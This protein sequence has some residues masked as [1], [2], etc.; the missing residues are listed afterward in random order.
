MLEVPGR[1]NEFVHNKERAL[2]LYEGERAEHSGSDHERNR[3]ELLHSVIVDEDFAIIGSQVD[4]ITKRKIWDGG[5]VDFARLILRDRL[6][7]IEDERRMEFIMRD[8]QTFLTPAADR[9]ATAI[10]SFNRREQAFRVFLVIYT[11]AFPNRAKELI[12]YNQVIFQAS[13]TFQWENVYAYDRDFHLHLSRHPN[14]TW[15]VILQQSWT[16]RMKDRLVKHQSGNGNSYSGR[17]KICWQYNKGK[18][19]FGV[20]CKFE[21]KCSVP[22]CGKYGHGAHICRKAKNNNFGYSGDCDCD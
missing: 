22:D 7:S 21:H 5:Y 6:H 18:C 9:D 4:D 12:H 13:I 16:L 17:K 2:A 8:G 20:N 1:N 14:R 11:E 10:S 3:S 19:N 15:S